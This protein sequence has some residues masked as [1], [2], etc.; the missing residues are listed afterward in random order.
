MGKTAI[1]FPGIGY[2]KDKPL[3]YYSRC[4]AKE[5]GYS[6]E[7]IDFLGIVWEK[8]DLRDPAKMNEFFV[9][10]MQCAEKSLSGISVAADDELLFISKSIGTVV[11]ACYAKEKG[12]NVKQIY[13]S[14]IVPFGIYAQDYGMAFY[15]DNDPLADYR[16]IEGICVDKKIEAHRIEGGNH[17]LETGDTERDLKK[18][19]W[20]MGMVK[21]F[22]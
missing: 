9:H 10:T 18:L 8:G 1:I 5:A 22:I 12:L 20:M 19:A 21:T 7:C 17:S 16:E 13:F 4:L 3:L 14:P 15:G 11:A 6:V 2:H